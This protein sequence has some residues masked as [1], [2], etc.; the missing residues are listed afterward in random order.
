MDK[1]RDMLRYNFRVILYLSILLLVFQNDNALAKSTN[2]NDFFKLAKKAEQL[3]KSQN[4]RT[5]EGYLLRLRIEE[6]FDI[7]KLKINKKVKGRFYFYVCDGERVF[8]QTANRLD[9]VIYYCSKSY[10]NYNKA[11][12]FD[13]KKLNRNLELYLSESIAS[14]SA[15]EYLLRGGIENKK[16]AKKHVTKLLDSN[17]KKFYYRKGL[18]VMSI[19]SRAE[20]NVE[21]QIIY[22]NKIIDWLECNNNK[23]KNFKKNIKKC[24]NEKNDLAA[25]FIDSNKYEDAKKIYEE[26]ILNES[27]YNVSRS[28]KVASRYGL[29]SYYIQIGNYEKAQEYLF[30]AL[31]YFRDT[32][33]K[34]NEMY[35][36]YIERLNYIF[37]I[38]GER[39][40]SIKGYNKLIDD[41]KKEYGDYNALLI[42]PLSS[43]IKIYYKMSHEEKRSNQLN[44]LIKTLEKN[45]DYKYNLNVYYANIAEVYFSSDDLTNAEKYYHKSLTINK[46]VGRNNIL[47]SLI[48]VKIFLDKFEEA[49]KLMKKVK[50]NNTYQKMKYHQTLNRLYFKTK[51]KDKFRKNYFDSYLLISDYSKGILETQD[52]GDVSFWFGGHIIEMLEAL[53]TMPKQDYNLLAN[54][55]ENNTGKH[56]NDTRMELFEILRSSKI[57]QRLQD[58]VFKSQNPK[59]KKEKRK[60]ENLIID[61]KKIPKFAESKSETEQLIKKMKTAKNKIAAQ[62]EIILKK[63]DVS[64]ISN[65]SKEIFR[66]DIQKTLKNDQ[67]LV[68]Y[69]FTHHYLH[70]LTISNKKTEV[71]VI[72]TK[73]KD[74]KNKIKQI[75][76]TVKVNKVNQLKTFDFDNT[77]KLYRIVLKPIEKL[78]K[79]KKELII[80]PHGALM[81]LPFGILTKDKIKQSNQIEYQNVNWLG[82]KYSINYYPSIYSFY[83]LQKIKSK[84]NENNFAGFGDPEFN[85]KKD[86]KL[87]SKSDLSNL[88]MSRGIANADEIRKLSELPETSDELKFIANL[89]KGKSK[90]YLRKDFDEEK[91]KSLDLSNYKYISFATHAIVADQINNISEPGI[92][93]TPP[94]KS[95]KTNDGI[96]T[97]SEIERLKL[98]SDIVILSACNTASEDGTPNAEGL[99][100]LTS[101]FFQA[102]TKSMMV[103]HWDVETNSAVTLTTGTFDKMVK[104]KNLSKA[105][106]KTKIE[107]MN[108]PK[109][110]HPF[111][112]APFILIGNLNL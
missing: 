91:I 92:I 8:N 36:F 22:Q 89:F 3:D 42:S 88:T 29:H 38:M 55:I 46:D 50:P 99:S 108:D 37:N 23:S 98:N 67:I 7:T 54:Y 39:D 13:D 84:N 106:H 19:L 107:M 33:K 25:V 44:Y 14:F 17:K 62:N 21:A 96:L 32:D 15:W 93:L 47:M 75:L 74:I 94:K 83:N 65:F 28:D 16:K 86:I 102:G 70:I 40:Q 82:K 69:F 12:N 60:L 1:I 112:W 85:S 43:V 58:L 52:T 66:D 51:Q 81:S 90:L 11:K 5:K 45:S 20:D 63:L 34:G 77:N 64:K 24:Y 48:Q 109:T 76:S 6:D 71:K 56:I 73:N 79:D 27:K 57:N 104:L 61:F 68:S 41:I 4:K 30:D 103:T 101:A 110:S 53:H 72:E 2:K 31:S 87:A 35:F 95:T 18:K 78:I 9:K 105:M 10:E 49:E 97:V 26:L 80:I 111:Y 100:G 59:I